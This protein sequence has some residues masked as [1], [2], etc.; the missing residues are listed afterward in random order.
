MFGRRGK[1]GTKPVTFWRTFKAS[2]CL[3]HVPKT[4]AMSSG[5]LHAWFPAG[6]GP[7]GRHFTRFAEKFGS[8]LTFAPGCD[9]TGWLAGRRALVV[10]RP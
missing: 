9:E 8:F 1:L 2:A 5:S 4:V 7:K 3:L 6:G 10:E